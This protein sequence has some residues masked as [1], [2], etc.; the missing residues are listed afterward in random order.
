MTSIENGE[1]EY[2]KM[3]LLCLSF[4]LTPLDSLRDYFQ[5]FSR[6]FRPI[7]VYLSDFSN[8]APLGSW[9]HVQSNTKQKPLVKAFIWTKTRWVNSTWMCDLVDVCGLYSGMSELYLDENSFG[10]WILI[11]V[12]V[13]LS[14][15][16]ISVW[17]VWWLW[18]CCSPVFTLSLSLSLSPAALSANVN[19]WYLWANFRL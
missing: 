19:K 7:S 10:S 15:L 2:V 6:L 1:S 4:S 8:N 3:T 17:F 14:T 5:F 18:M 13:S 11:A 16:P 9:N 12:P